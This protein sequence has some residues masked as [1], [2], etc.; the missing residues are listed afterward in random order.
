M[1]VEVE[2]ALPLVGTISAIGLPWRVMTTRSPSLHLLEEGGE[3]G[4]GF[5]DGGFDHAANMVR[6]GHIGNVR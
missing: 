5:V 4:L 6:N 1:G 2:P 3:L